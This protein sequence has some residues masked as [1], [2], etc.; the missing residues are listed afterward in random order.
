MPYTVPQFIER[1]TKI[2]GPFTFK[3]LIFLGAAAALIVLFYFTLPFFL[4]IVVA[5]LVGGSALALSFAKVAGR[6][7]PI[8]IKNFLSFSTSSKIYFWKKKM[9]PPKIVKKNRVSKSE[10]HRSSNLK[11]PDLK[12]GQGAGLRELSTF[13]ETKTG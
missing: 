8:V 10:P 5:I 2:A 12:K 4:F 9:I 13:L 6:P 1:E 7:L 11:S 3:Q